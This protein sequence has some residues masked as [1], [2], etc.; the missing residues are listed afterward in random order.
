MNRSFN[1]SMSFL[2]ILLV[3]AGV[4][5]SIEIVSLFGVVFLMVFGALAG[6]E[7]YGVKDPPRS[8]EKISS[9]KAFKKFVYANTMDGSPIKSSEEPQKD[10]V[11]ESRSGENLN[12][13]ELEE[14]RHANTLNLHGSYTETDVLNA[15][16]EL[17]KEYHPD[18]VEH[19]GPKLRTIAKAEEKMATEAWEYFRAKYN[20]VELSNTTRLD[21]SPVGLTTYLVMLILAFGMG[22]GL[23]DNDYGYYVLL[24]WVSTFGF[25]YITMQV[26]NANL[27]TLTWVFALFASIYNPIL[28]LALGKEL[29]TIVN[30]I[31]IGVLMF[32]VLPMRRLKG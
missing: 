4:L 16:R 9:S 14:L 13:N 1:I 18:I 6:L 15:Y 22:F 12:N 21:S 25:L 7:K 27:N 31:T 11:S 29:W 28:P 23:L 24:K 17:A 20:W 10:E 3:I 19:L 26:Y 5:N 2:G 30:I 32:S 8:S